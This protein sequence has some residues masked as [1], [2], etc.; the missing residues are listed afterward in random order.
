MIEFRA[1]ADLIGNAQPQRLMRQ[2]PFEPD[3]RLTSAFRPAA[4]PYRTTL[5]STVL[6]PYPPSTER[7]SPGAQQVPSGLEWS[8]DCFRVIPNRFPALNPA[9]QPE[10]TNAAKLLIYL[11]LAAFSVVAG[12]GFEPTTFRL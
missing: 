7:P 10:T 4:A 1:Q 11:N 8:G 3:R 12:V 6:A 2:T 9:S 5:P